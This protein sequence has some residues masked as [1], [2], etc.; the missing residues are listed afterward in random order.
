MIATLASMA[1]W[2]RSTLDS[3]A[4]PCSVKALGKKRLP[5][6]PVF[7]LPNWKIKALA[8]SKVRPNEKSGGNRDGLRDTAWFKL[9]VVTPYS[10]AKSASNMTRCPRITWIS[11]SIF[12][13]SILSYE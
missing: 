7:D 11:P 9:P 2:L 13:I 1:L 10:A 3:M 6:L 12:E 5:P 8:S 4:T